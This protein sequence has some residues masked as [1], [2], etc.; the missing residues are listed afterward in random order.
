MCYTYVLVLKDVLTTWREVKMMGKAIQ[1]LVTE[2]ILCM[3]VPTYQAV[4]LVETLY[5]YTPSKG[6]EV[7]YIRIWLDGPCLLYLAVPSS[8]AKTPSV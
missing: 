1:I 2:A 8:Y 3:G 5:Y 4:M 7:L 6:M